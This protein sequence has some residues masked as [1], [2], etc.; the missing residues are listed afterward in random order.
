MT[1][2]EVE[3]I[4]KGHLLQDLTGYYILEEILPLPEDYKK[5][6]YFITESNQ[7][8]YPPSNLIRWHNAK[9]GDRYCYDLIVTKIFTHTF[10][11]IK[12]PKKTETTSENLYL[13][14][15]SRLNKEYELIKEKHESLKYLINY[16]AK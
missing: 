12:K 5:E 6:D 4:T 1:A 15:K 9:I 3:I 7:H 10:K 14:N 2:E 16:E 8:L 11:R 13:V